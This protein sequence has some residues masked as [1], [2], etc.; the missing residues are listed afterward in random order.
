MPAVTVSK[1]RGRHHEPA[2]TPTHLAG[3]IK[4]LPTKDALSSVPEGFDEGGFDHPVVILSPKSQGGKVIILIMT[5]F[6]GVELKTKHASNRKKRIEYLPIEP[7]DPHPDNGILLKLR[8]HSPGMWK[9]TY[10]HT[11]DLRTIRLDLLR[12]C[13]RQGVEL[14]LSPESYRQLADYA[15]FH[16]TAPR[17]Q[18]VSV[19]VPATPPPRT[20]TRAAT[21]APTAP[22]SQRTTTPPPPSVRRG[23]AAAVPRA[24]RVAPRGLPPLPQQ[25]QRQ[26]LSPEDFASYRQR[27]AAVL[28]RRAELAPLLPPNTHGGYGYGYVSST[29]TEAGEAEPPSGSSSSGCSR[30]ARFLWLVLRVALGVLACYGVYRGYTWATRAIAEAGQRATAFAVDGI[31][32]VVRDGGRRVAAVAGKAFWA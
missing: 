6:G 30:F 26:Q 18:T 24:D 25:R 16:A 27:M 28:A 11:T 14:S 32:G 21:W 29:R 2:S 31:Q 19:S 4:W 13:E 7:C 23:S 3:S 15:K 22:P 1:S 12:A 17:P 10:V 5:S 20:P 8:S 9:K